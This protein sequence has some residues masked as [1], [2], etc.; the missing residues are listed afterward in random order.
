MM[1]KPK[2]G[3]WATWLLACAW[4]SFNILRIEG[5]T[6]RYTISPAAVSRLLQAEGVL[7]PAEQLVLPPA[8]SATEASPSL[9]LQTAELLPDG[10]L[11]VR[12]AC[13]RAAACH[14]FFAT[15]RCTASEGG[16]AM[17]ARLQRQPEAGSPAARTSEP[18][19]L[20]AGRQVTLSLETRRMRITLPVIAIDSGKP[21]A[22]VRV[23]SLDRKQV[24]RAVV[25]D[26]GSVRGVLP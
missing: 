16:L 22:E 23:A 19:G 12:I 7:A 26:A 9:R 1:Q 21:G 4:V 25:A 2:T 18:A 20:V 11:R 15:A 8:L 10:R 14:P 5:Q 13:Q 17:L 6:V 3:G 24:Y